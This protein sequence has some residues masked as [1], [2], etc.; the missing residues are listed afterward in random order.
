MLGERPDQ[1][2]LCN[3]RFLRFSVSLESMEIVRLW[4]L[5]SP[6]SRME[7][8]DDQPVVG[9]ANFLGRY[10][11]YNEKTGRSAYRGPGTDDTLRVCP[12]RLPPR[13]PRLDTSRTR[14]R[15]P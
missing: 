14:R 7:N 8:L 2:G 10:E 4:P 3:V 11:I 9:K 5:S 13:G 15:R 12:Q 6:Q 1:R